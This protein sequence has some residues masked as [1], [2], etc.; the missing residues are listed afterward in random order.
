MHAF[1]VAASFTFLWVH[2]CSV[3]D[4]TCYQNHGKEVEKK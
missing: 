4:S 1:E 2:Y 3:A